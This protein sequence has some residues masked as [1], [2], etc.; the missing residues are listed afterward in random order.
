MATVKSR[1]DD[2]AIFGGKP[3]FRSQLHVGRPNIGD[4]QTLLKRINDLLDRRW[5]T[6]DGPFLQEFEQRICHLTGVKHCVAVCNATVD[7]EILAR[8]AA[9]RAIITPL[10]G[11]LL[12]AVGKLGVAGLVPLSASAREKTRK[13][14]PEWT[15]WFGVPANKLQRDE[16]IF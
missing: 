12:Y 2:L 8:A 15:I 3:A 1:V 13:S 11:T 14:I 16:K 5:L 9:S 4:R 10:V 6:N 7:L